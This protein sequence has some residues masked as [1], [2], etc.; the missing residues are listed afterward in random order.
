MRGWGLGEGVLIKMGFIFLL[1]RSKLSD[2][3]LWGG[4]EEERGIEGAKA[5]RL[6]CTC[7][8]QRTVRALLCFLTL[9]PH[10]LPSSPATQA[11]SC[12]SSAAPRFRAS[13][14]DVGMAI[15]LAGVVVWISVVP[16]A[17]MAMAAQLGWRCPDLV[18][19]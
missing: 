2:T 16:P 19:I 10:P 7:R 11:H 15:L 8:R 9:S 13:A 17:G 4:S 1:S 3:F 12:R 18:Q 5:A 14:G 6:E